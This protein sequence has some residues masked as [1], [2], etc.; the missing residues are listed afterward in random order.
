MLGPL[1]AAI[2]FQQLGGKVRLPPIPIACAQSIVGCLVASSI[3]ASIVSSFLDRWPMFLAISLLSVS[4]SLALGWA[5]GRFRILPGSTAVWGMLPGVSTVMILL[6]EAFQADFRL[7]AFMQYIRVVMVAV[8]ASVIARFV[9]PLSTRPFVESLFQP[10][11]VADLIATAA[12]ALFGG[13]MGR[14]IRIPGGGLLVPLVLGAVLNALEWVHI[15]LPPIVLIACY[16]VIGWNTGL[17][18]TPEILAAAS[19]VV[20]QCVGAAILLMSFCGLLAWLLVLAAH[21]DPLTAYLSTSPGGIDSIAII[22]TGA[23]VDMRFVMAL[24]TMRILIL[25]LAGP[26]AAK[27]IAKVLRTSMQEASD[28]DR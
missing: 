20:A 27:W 28:A 23:H 9:A 4:A 21:V 6:S 1:V 22:A 16:A 17:R 3:N 18:F 2:L 24:Q 15:V 14:L 10:V 12:I 7:V 13:V 25:L 19:R 26:S 11:R 8:T 5:M